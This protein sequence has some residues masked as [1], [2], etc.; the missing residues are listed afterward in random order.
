MPHGR[1]ATPST[2]HVCRKTVPAAIQRRWSQHTSGVHPSGT[3][4][5]LS[6]DG[7]REFHSPV[8][9][10]GRR[11]GWFADRPLAVKFGV[12]LAAVV[13]AFGGVIG[14]VLVGN[15]DVREADLELGPASNAAQELVLQLD[16]RAS[17]LKVDGFKALMRA[18]PG[19]AA[20]R[21]RRR[22]RH[23]ARQCWSS[24]RRSRWTGAAADCRGRAPDVLRGL[25]R[26]DLRLGGPARWPTR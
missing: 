8:A 4:V 3:C 6:L 5:T 17:E 19:G 20:A 25:H 10:P 21:A 14:A 26:R 7:P 23:A 18:G 2:H 9:A 22:H 15:A 24:W 13:L 12:L 11:A 16:T 1:T